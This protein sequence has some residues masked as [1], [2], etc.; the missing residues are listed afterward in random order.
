MTRTPGPHSGR[1]SGFSAVGGA[2]HNRASELMKAAL[3]VRV[4][5]ASGLCLFPCGG[6]LQLLN[7]FLWFLVG[8]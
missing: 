7:F 1:G 6:L 5:G 4:V 3:C 2:P 8:M